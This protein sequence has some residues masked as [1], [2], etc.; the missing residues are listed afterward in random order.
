MNIQ[1][2]LSL[3]AIA[4]SSTWNSFVHA[5]PISLESLQKQIEAQQAQ[6][7]VLQSQ[8]N[9]SQL[10][11]AKS[12]LT[13]KS[14]GNLLYRS[15]PI[16][17]NTQD[18][19]PTRRNTTDVERVVTEFEYKL[20][21]NWEL[22]FEIEYEHGGTGT[23]LEYDGFEE[24]GEFESEVEAGGEVIVEKLQ[25]KHEINQH[26]SIKF[27]HIYVPVGL[28]TMLNK[29]TQHFTTTRHWSESTIIPQVWHETGVNLISTWNEL[30]LQTLLTTGLNSEYFRTTNWIAGGLQQRF[31]NVNADDLA[32]TLRLDYGDIKSGTGIGVSYYLSDTSDNRR[33]QDKIAAKGQVTLL[34]LSGAWK[35]GSW[36]FRGQYLYGELNDSHL[37]TAA[38]KTT[39]GLK[40]GNFAQVGSEAESFYLE[41]AYDLKTYLNRQLPMQL[42]TSFDYA[43]PIKNVTSGSATNRFDIQEFSIGINYYPIRDLVLKLQASERQYA[44]SNLDNTTHISA[45]VGYVFNTQL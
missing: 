19:D 6:I 18:T 35:H 26:F 22:E 28:G 10:T 17:A 2:P 12:P 39:P 32:L 15:D 3:L 37:I 11:E 40:P 31:E 34:A 13:F 16:F 25:L 24:F 36:Q 1:T 43:N 30:T 21:P 20:T 14:Y 33:N 27:G 7:K 42:F 5:E 38:N 44:Q 8:T 41:A 4:L 9:A 29:P 23:T 45:S